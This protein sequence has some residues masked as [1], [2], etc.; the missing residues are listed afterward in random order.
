MD[1]A[2]DAVFGYSC[3]NDISVRNYQRKT[4]QWTI[5]KNFDR[6]GG[7]GPVLVTQDELP[8]GATNL[9]SQSRLNGQIMQDANTRDMIWGVAETIVLLSECV[10]L[11]PGD[12]IIMGTPAGVG[13]ARTP[14]VWMKAGDS[15]DIEIEQIGILHN[16]IENEAA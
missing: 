6:T 3:F 5:G 2:L 15:I 12:L 10:T 4:P 13:H 7:F 16:T 9:R 11:E 8:E 14:Q 1:N